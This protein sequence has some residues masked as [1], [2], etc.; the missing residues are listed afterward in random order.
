LSTRDKKTADD[1][2]DNIAS[3]SSV[4]NQWNAK[5]FYH[6]KFF[7]KVCELL[8]SLNFFFYSII[9]AFSYGVFI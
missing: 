9:C 3:F 2:D 6:L 1:D 5:C 7:L 8:F 4:I